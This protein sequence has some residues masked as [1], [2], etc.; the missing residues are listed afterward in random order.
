MRL[1]FVK[2]SQLE[3][4]QGSLDRCRLRN[5]KL[6]EKY[7]ALQARCLMAE[8]YAQVNVET[9]EWVREHFELYT[10]PP[11]YDYDPDSTPKDSKDV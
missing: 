7:T 8:G 10:G 6:H 9:V 1:P 5:Q 11:G 3:E 4:T 2:R